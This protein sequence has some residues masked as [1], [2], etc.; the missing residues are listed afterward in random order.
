MIEKKKEI[1]QMPVRNQKIISLAICK[2]N[3][4]RKILVARKMLSV[5]E[6]GQRVNNSGFTTGYKVIITCTTQ[7]HKSIQHKGLPIQNIMGTEVNNSGLNYRHTEINNSELY[8]TQRIKRSGI[9]DRQRFN[10]SG[11]SYMTYKGLTIQDYIID[12]IG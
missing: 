6:Q 10:N 9:Y 12:T 8:H 1:I 11:S 2:P 4:T 5:K 7:Q 3:K